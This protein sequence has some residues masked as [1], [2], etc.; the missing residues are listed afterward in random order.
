[1]LADDT[2]SKIENITAG[3]IL[4]GQSDYCTAARNLLCSRYSTSTTVKKD[5]EGQSI[6]K[7][8]QAQNLEQFC[9]ESSLWVNPLPTEKSFLIRGGEAR[10]FLHDDNRHVIKLNDG[11]YYATWLEFLNSILLHNL[12]FPNTAYE[13]VGFAKEGESLLAV[14]K[15]PFVI[16]DAVVDLGDI[17]AFLEFNGFQNTRRHDYEHRQLGLILEDMHD[18]NVLVNSETLFFI[19]TVFY[20]VTPA[21]T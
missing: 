7:K 18:E 1:M 16:S 2:Q 13:L 11:V 3:I 6:I 8:E 10:V 21:V 4:K 17:K 19:D 5:F 14:L 12:I 15:Q 20:T 9:T